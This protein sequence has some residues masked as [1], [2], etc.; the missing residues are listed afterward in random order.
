MA[1]TVSRILALNWCKLARLLHNGRSYFSVEF[2]SDASSIHFIVIC[3][4]PEAE[5]SAVSEPRFVIK[6]PSSVVVKAGETVQWECAISSRNTESFWRR[7]GL[8]QL[9]HQFIFVILRLLFSLKN[10]TSNTGKSIQVCRSRNFE[11]VNVFFGLPK[12]HCLLLP[13]TN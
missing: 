13:K 2:P 12:K 11:Q 9:V 4:C 10:H 1:Q 7:Q 6:P 3:V 8:S 5:E